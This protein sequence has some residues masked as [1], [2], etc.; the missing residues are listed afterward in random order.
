MPKTGRTGTVRDCMAANL[1][2]FHPDT[3]IDEAIEALAPVGHQ[4]ATGTAEGFI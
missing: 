2:T 1:V 3:E 4:A